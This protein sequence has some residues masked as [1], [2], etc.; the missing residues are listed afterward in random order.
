MDGLHWRQTALSGAVTAGFYQELATHDKRTSMTVC[1]CMTSWPSV[2]LSVP[3][4]GS[5]IGML[6]QLSTSITVCSAS[7]WCTELVAHLDHYG[8]ASKDSCREGV[9][10]IVEGVVPRNN[11]SHLHSKI[12][13]MVPDPWDMKA[14]QQ[15]SR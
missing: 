12:S 14:Q 8:I 6:G 1:C 7:G 11:S 10:N 2:G 9:E 13:L 4:R 3:M 15:C 5:W